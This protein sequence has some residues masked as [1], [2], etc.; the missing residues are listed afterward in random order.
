MGY[1]YFREFPGITSETIEELTPY[2]N[3]QFTKAF[4]ANAYSIFADND[5][6]NISSIG[7]NDSGQCCVGHEKSPISKLTPITFFN[8]N[9]IIIKK[10][11]ANNGGDAVFFITNEHKLYGA[12]K[13]EGLL[14][15]RASRPTLMPLSDVIQAKA[16]LTCCIALCSSNNDILCKIIQNWSRLYAVPDDVVSILLLF[17]KSTTVYS[18]TKKP[19][20]GHPKHSILPNE[21]DWNVVKFFDDKHVIKID[22]GEDH[23]VFLDDT[24]TVYSCGNSYMA[25]LGLIHGN[26]VYIPEIVRYFTDNDIKIVDIAVGAYHNLA[27]D[28]DGKVY[29]W[30]RNDKGQCGDGTSDAEVKIPKLV[31]DLEG[32]RVVVIKCGHNHSYCRTECGKHFIWGRNT[33]SAC[34]RAGERNQLKPWRFDGML[35]EK[36]GVNKIVEVCMGFSNTRIVVQ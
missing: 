27:L 25:R 28:E 13:L 10:I 15:S 9:N 22:T 34:L 21:N 2:P 7:Y 14:K 4:C 30:G 3:T 36:Y 20:S 1:N 23:T 35:K 8:D 16:T 12:G 11:C 18:T 33:Y 31:E 17:S 19:G 24:G 26:D 5:Y 6:K 32:Y 29:S